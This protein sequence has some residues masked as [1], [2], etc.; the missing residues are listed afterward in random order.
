MQ[1]HQTLVNR[2]SFGKLTRQRQT[3]HVGHFARRHVGRNRNHAYA[4]E[5]HEVHTG[6]IVTAQQ[7]KVV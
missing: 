2:T 1:W 4:A 3:A 7:N 6:R 5:L